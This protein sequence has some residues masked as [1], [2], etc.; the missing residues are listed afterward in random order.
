MQGDSTATSLLAK[1]DRMLETQSKV[2]L[3]KGTNVGPKG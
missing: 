3:E 2:Q 1:S